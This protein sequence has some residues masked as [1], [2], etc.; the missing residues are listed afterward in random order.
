VCS[1]LPEDMVVGLE[2]LSDGAQ[3]KNLVVVLTLC[4]GTE[5]MKKRCCDRRAGKRRKELKENVV[6]EL[7]VGDESELW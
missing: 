2:E 7:G 5:E 1:C 3:R 6:L 4:P